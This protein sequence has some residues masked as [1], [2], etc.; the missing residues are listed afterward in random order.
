[1]SYVRQTLRCEIVPGDAHFVVELREA[2]RIVRDVVGQELEGD[3][4]SE[5]EVVGAVDLAHAAAP[6]RRDD[7]EAAGED[8]A[9]REAAPVGR[10]T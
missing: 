2:R 10:S 8:G 7:A 9:R 5:L 6:E 3:R 1:M 4:L